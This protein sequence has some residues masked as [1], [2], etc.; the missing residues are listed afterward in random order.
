MG[1]YFGVAARHDALTDT[2]F[3]TDYHSHLG[4]A[5]AGM[6]VYDREVGLQREIHN[7]KNSPFRTKFEHVFDDMK[8]S[9]AIRCF[10]MTFG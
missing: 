9:S 5:R 6:A 8:G 4:T 3:G 2:F 10:V 1:G 7:I